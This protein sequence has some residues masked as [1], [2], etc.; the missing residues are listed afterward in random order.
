MEVD[1]DVSIE[2]EGGEAVLPDRGLKVGTAVKKLIKG[3]VVSIE[4]IRFDG[5]SQT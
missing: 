4:T 5:Q 1:D 2:V 3:D